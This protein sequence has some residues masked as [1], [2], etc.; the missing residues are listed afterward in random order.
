MSQ[1]ILAS[2]SRIRADMLR[3]AGIA[4]EI[5]PSDV[6]EGE[7]KEDC[8]RQ[9]HDI[10]DMA[11]RLA[12]A[13]ASAVSRQHPDAYVIGADQILGLDAAPFDKPATMTQAAERLRVLSGRTHTLHSAACI[14]KNGAPLWQALSQPTL[15]M[16]TLAQQ[17]IENYLAATGDIVLSS[18]G[19]YQLEKQ[20]A[21][22]FTAVQGD[23]FAIL[24]LPLLPL[25]A[26]LRDQNLIDY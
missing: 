16:R 23:Y 20:G 10:P 19:A 8:A 18:V 26:F 21:R 7:I 24:G 3:D 12:Q 5:V 25:L 22:L 6:D 1:I 2:G 14:I 17:D 4:V 11:M 13:K 9:G 15:T